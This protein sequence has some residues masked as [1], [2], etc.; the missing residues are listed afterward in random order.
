MENPEKLATRRRKT[1]Q[2]HKMHWTPLCAHKHI[3]SI[4]VQLKSHLR[5]S[6]RK[7]R[8]RS[9]VRK[10]VRRMRNRKLRNIHLSRAF[11]P[12]VTSVTWPEEALSG[13]GPYRKYVLRMP[14]FFPAFFLSY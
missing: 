10:Y 7:W 11:P 1:K 8:D 4:W 13:S 14:G 6:N 3:S 12:E 9:H 5:V 2:Q